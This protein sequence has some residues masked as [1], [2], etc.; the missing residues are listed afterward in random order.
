MILDKAMTP[1]FT[2]FHKNTGRFSKIDI[3]SNYNLTD[4]YSTDV[5]F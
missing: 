5:K 3:I 4:S 2:L 1:V